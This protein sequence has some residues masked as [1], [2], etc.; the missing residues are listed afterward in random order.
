MLAAS[1]AFAQAE[2]GIDKA[3]ADRLDT[4]IFGGNPGKKS[5]ACFVRRYDADHLARHPRQKLR[6]MLLLLT[7]EV[8]DGET[9]PSYSFQLG[10]KYRNRPGDFD[11]AGGCSHAIAEDNVNAIGFDC[12]VDC[13]GGGI[14][15]APAKDD[16][17][18][19]VRLDRI[20]I[21]RRGKAGDQT[22]ETLHAGADDRIFRLDRTDPADCA[23]LVADGKE[24]A[25]TGP[26]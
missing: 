7:A 15:V 4:R 24:L 8:E 16:K 9:E 20:G 11:S 23:P 21:W 26:E 19:I 12:S 3:K 2:D 6:A 13:D 14:D 25:S 1:A 17:S 10:V 18:V 22:P 5:S